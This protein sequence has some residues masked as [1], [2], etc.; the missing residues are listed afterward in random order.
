MTDPLER[1]CLV[2]APSGKDAALISSAL[3]RASIASE[4]CR[5]AVDL[6]Q[7][8]A[9][10]AGA[11]ML[12]EEAL[13][14][15]A[16]VQ[17]LQA[18]IDRQPPWSDLPVV[19]LTKAGPASRLALEVG[20]NLGNV[21]VL[22]RP[23][24]MAT[25]VSAVRT[26]LRT[27][28]R[29]YLARAADQRK[30]QFLATLAH[31]LRNPLAPMTNALHLLKREDVGAD[32]RRWSL[33]VMQRQLVQM[34]RLVD[35]L[36]DVAR[37]SQG[38]VPLKKRLV[39]A[40]EVIHNAV[41]ISAPWIQSMRHELTTRVPGTP[42][43]VEADPVRLAQCV[44][45]LLNN[46]AKYTPEGGRIELDVACAG[47]QLEIAVRDNGIGIPAPALKQ[48]FTIFTQ[49]DHAG[50]RSQGGLGIGL[51]IVKT[52]IE[53]HGGSVDAHSDGEGRGSTFVAR[54]PLAQ[55]CEPAVAAL[56]TRDTRR[57]VRSRRILVVDDNVDGADSLS[58]LLGTCG[59]AVTRAYSGQAGIEAA[60]AEP[61]DL[62]ILDIGL[63]DMTG[64]DL[65]LRLRAAPATARTVLVA[66]SGWGQ[67]VDRERSAQAGFSHHLVKPADPADVLDL[68]QAA[69]RRPS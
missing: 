34:T 68:I 25:L 67:A 32:V 4:V 6:A 21:T 35:D 27:R 9:R 63:P 13:G 1:R 31:E 51:S 12:A 29:Q 58:L 20:R 5:T 65:A 3:A 50:A 54:L 48:L 55:S 52:F 46:A 57:D 38:K 23:T 16:S 8:A 66:L 61:P 17:A 60:F 7:E 15:T 59:H 22:E 37:I 28:E 33:G 11:L 69:T 24:P 56:P 47:T 14:D 41:E 45:N 30:D 36:L 42:V 39:D 64:Y 62:A 53:M 49:L 44:S 43:L 19:L 26:A 2:I 40:R 18:L 10:G